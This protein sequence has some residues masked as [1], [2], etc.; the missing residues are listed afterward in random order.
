MQTNGTFN[1][2]FWNWEKYTRNLA[3]NRKLD[4]D[5]VR[6]LSTTSI[7]EASLNLCSVSQNEYKSE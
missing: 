2:L 3:L 1:D 5:H 4:N 7:Y 6:Q